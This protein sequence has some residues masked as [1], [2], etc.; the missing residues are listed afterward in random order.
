MTPKKIFEDLVE[1]AKNDAF[2]AE[3]RTANLLDDPLERIRLTTSASAYL[4]SMQYIGLYKIV[5][6]KIADDMIDQT[7]GVLQEIKATKGNVDGK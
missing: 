4:L 7:I 2:A 3:L 5:P 6:N 1:K